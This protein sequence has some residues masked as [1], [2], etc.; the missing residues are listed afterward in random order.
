MNTTQDVIVNILAMGFSIFMV[1][2]FILIWV[3]TNKIVDNTKK[4]EHMTNLN[5]SY[6]TSCFDIH[7]E[8]EC[9]KTALPKQYCKWDQDEDKCHNP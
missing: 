9:N 5:R 1:V 4:N 7:D 3:N 8:I 2:I 6:L